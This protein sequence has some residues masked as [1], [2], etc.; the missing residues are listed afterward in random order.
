[1]GIPEATS[2]EWIK[3]NEIKPVIKAAKVQAQK[4][5]KVGLNN[6]VIAAKST[7]PLNKMQLQNKLSKICHSAFCALD[8]AR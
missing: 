6:R 5:K 3:T 7:R 8:V 4:K 1:M 2:Q